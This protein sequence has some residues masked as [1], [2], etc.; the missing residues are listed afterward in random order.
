MM[1]TP[2]TTVSSMSVKPLL[3]VPERTVVSHLRPLPLRTCQWNDPCNTPGNASRRRTYDYLWIGQG[4][5][6]VDGE[7]ATDLVHCTLRGNA[8]INVKG[9]I[10]LGYLSISVDRT[11]DGSGSIAL[12]K[13]AVNE[14]RDAS[15]SSRQACIAA[16]REIPIHSDG[17]LHRPTCRRRRTLH[18]VRSAVQVVL[19]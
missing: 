7:A 6:E 15:R 9:T 18:I 10:H 3:W 11:D 17:P 16:K 4:R 19:K 1:M 5:F 13:V 8:S 12:D 2:T 14:Q